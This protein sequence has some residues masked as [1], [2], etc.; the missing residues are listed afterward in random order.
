M[1]GYYKDQKAT[2][3]TFKDGWFWSGDAAVLNPMVIFR[4]KIAS[5]M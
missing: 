4:L 2:E 3:E 5:K 1:K